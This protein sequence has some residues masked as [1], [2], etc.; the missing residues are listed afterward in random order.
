MCRCCSYAAVVMET[1]LWWAAGMQRGWTSN[2]LRPACSDSS[3][4]ADFM[5]Y[6]AIHLMAQ[7]K[8]KMGSNGLTAFG[9]VRLC[10]LCCLFKILFGTIGIFFLHLSYGLWTIN[11]KGC[12]SIRKEL[13]VSMETHVLCAAL[14]TKSLILVYLWEILFAFL[15]CLQT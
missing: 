10:F 15:P 5:L 1:W 4:R 7:W 11:P 13:S 2:P 8:A 9:W 6:F 3:P 14:Q 12:Y